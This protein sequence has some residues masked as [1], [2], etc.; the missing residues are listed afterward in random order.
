MA[1]QGTLRDFALPD[2]IQLISLGKKTGAVEITSGDGEGT[3]FLYFSG[4]RVVSAQFHD[5]PPMD[6]ACQFFAF[7]TGYFR[8][9][10]DQQPTGE[11][12]SISNEMLILAGIQRAEEWKEISTKISSPGVVMKLKQEAGGSSI[13]LK[14][15]EWR[16]LTMINGRDSISNISQKTGLGE[17]K[18]SKI[19]FHLL[20]SG[21]VEEVQVTPESTAAAAAAAAA[22]AIR[23]ETGPLINPL[24]GTG[25]LRAEVIRAGTA[26]LR[27]DAI[28]PPT[29]GARPTPRRGTA[30]L[31]LP[32]TP[33][34]PPPDPNAPKR[35]PALFKR[36]EGLAIAE[37]GIT[38]RMLLNEAYRRVRLDPG[39]ELDPATAGD[40]CDQFERSA[41]V[42]LGAVRARNLSN[43]LRNATAEIY[44]Q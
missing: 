2:I 7:K 13:S 40:L 22:A 34:P 3:G 5:L 43:M 19:V 14:P 28:R 8:F 30:P 23:P 11:L 29:N 16:V 36:L 25:P 9:I 12:I 17:F 4:G 31:R 42:L 38:G 44:S 33:P 41:T 6:A 21:L 10:P 15:E 1:L 20:S 24:P 35:G 27:S 26:P 37:L 18:T 39:S 32:D